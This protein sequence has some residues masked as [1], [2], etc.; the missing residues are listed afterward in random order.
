M[1]LH[2]N[3]SAVS[4]AIISSDNKFFG[5]SAAPTA[6]EVMSREVVQPTAGPALTSGPTW[7]VSLRCSQADSE[8]IA[9]GRERF[10][11]HVS[12]A[13]DRPFLRL[14]HQDCADEAPDQCLVRKDADNVCAPLDLAG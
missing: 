14:L 12:G 2:L 11:R 1:K 9:D 8:I 10:Q 4:L 7:S 6:T 13:L 3:Q 5:L